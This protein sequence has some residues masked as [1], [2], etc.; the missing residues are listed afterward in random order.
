LPTLWIKDF[1]LLPQLKKNLV[2]V[3]WAGAKGV[4]LLLQSIGLFSIND[5]ETAQY[6]SSP[7]V[8]VSISL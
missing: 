4:G 3:L 6:S 5:W 2:K 7:K 8:N 1:R